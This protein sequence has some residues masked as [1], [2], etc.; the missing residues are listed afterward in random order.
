MDLTDIYGLFHL[1]PA[2]YTFF[3]ETNRNFSTTDHILGHEVSII[4]Y[5][6]YDNIEAKLELNS[7]RD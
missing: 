4:I 6:I 1:K 7:K 5:A 2:Q 3:S